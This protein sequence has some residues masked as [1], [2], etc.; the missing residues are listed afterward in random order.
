MSVTVQLSIVGMVLTRRSIV[1]RGLTHIFLV[2][3]VR[4]SVTFNVASRVNDL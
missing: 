2:L 3:K 4:F 1:D